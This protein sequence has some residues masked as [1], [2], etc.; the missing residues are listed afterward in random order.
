[1]E[2]Q[3]MPFKDL[4]ELTASDS[5]APGGGSVSA[6]VGALGA[7]LSEMV[8]SLTIG[9]KGYEDAVPEM[10][11]AAQKLKTLRVKLLDL[12]QEDTK[13]FNLFMDALSLPKSTDEE[14]AARKK[15]M[16]EALK[17]ASLTPLE[18]AKTAA[19]VVPLA[20][21]MALRGNQNAV[22]DA[23]V[24]AMCARTCVLGALLNVEI[25]LKSIKDEAFVKDAQETVL[26]LREN[27]IQAEARLLESVKI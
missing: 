14:K 16:Q 2:L 4:C 3:D 6:L 13:S 21:L 9:K 27:A 24:S 22:T 11:E 10:K 1:M 15:A 18:V 20:S 7:S 17:K 23:L 19:E 25:N 26:L 5:P 12:A 8:A